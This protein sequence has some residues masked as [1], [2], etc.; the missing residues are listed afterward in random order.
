MVQSS[1]LAE[2][3]DTGGSAVNDI[4]GR[5]TVSVMDLLTAAPRSG[6]L[7]IPDLYGRFLKAAQQNRLERPT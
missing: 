5:T 1:G 4:A 3:R 2:A 6:T 7:S